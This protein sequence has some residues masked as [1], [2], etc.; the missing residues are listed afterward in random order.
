MAAQIVV[1][2]VDAPVGTRVRR[3]YQGDSKGPDEHVPPSPECD[4]Y[5]PPSAQM[6]PGEIGRQ[7]IVHD[8]IEI[9]LVYCL[10]KQRSGDRATDV[11]AVYD[12]LN[13]EP[14]PV[15]IFCRPVSSLR[16]GSPYRTIHEWAFEHLEEAS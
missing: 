14:N 8:G 7:T 2:R 13:G 15:P 16:N 12:L 5:Y 4:P 1:K 9:V 10:L 11:L 3:R 6:L